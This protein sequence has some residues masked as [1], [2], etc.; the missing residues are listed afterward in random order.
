MTERYLLDA[1]AALNSSEVVLGGAEDGGY[2]LI[3][4]QKPHP[5]LFAGVDWGTERVFAQ[6]LDRA[7]AL[8]VSVVE[9]PTLWDID[10]VEDWRRFQQNA[11]TGYW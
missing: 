1:A 2:V 8:G 11:K 5:E 4:Q 3:G 6:T 10:N 9:L 7:A